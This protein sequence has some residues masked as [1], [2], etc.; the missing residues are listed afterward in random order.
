MQ[1]Q[2]NSVKFLCIGDLQIEEPVTWDF[3]KPAESICCVYFNSL[4]HASGYSLYILRLLHFA[5]SDKKNTVP[6]HKEIQN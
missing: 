3:P 1:K 4:K 5:E 6:C 2:N